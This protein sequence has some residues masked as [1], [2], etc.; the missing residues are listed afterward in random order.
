M[1]RAGAAL[2]LALSGCSGQ[3][4]IPGVGEPIVVR[5]A[6]FIS[7]PLPGTPPLDGGTPA[8]PAVTAIQSV[9]NAFVLGQAGASYSG[10]VSDDATAVAVRFP[11]FGTGY[12]VFVPGPPDA[13]D[14]GNLT[15]SM[16]FD[17]SRDVPPGLTTLR[18]AAIGPDGTSGTEVDQPVC[19]DAPIPDNYNA[20]FSSR[21]PP[22][23]VLSLSWDTPVDLDLQVVTPA[24]V[25]VS[26]KHPTTRASADAGPAPGDGAIDRD[27]DAN[28][29]T[30]G[31]NR[32]DL[33]WKDPPAPGIY[34]AYASLFSACGRPAVRFTLSLYV[35]EPVDGGQTLARKIQTSGELLATDENGG[36]GLGLYV[37]A[38]TFPS[39]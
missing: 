17:V 26:P 37:A 30:D 1:K 2:L 36:T 23:A 14:P 21:V 9:N 24:G 5:G 35:A 15:W 32:E 27:S 10:D 3:P 7:G 33:V 19:I 31:L 13:T 29:V 39:P 20:C 38:V 22:A 16:T 4:V 18:F 11:D 34:L 6:T 12:W 28:C 25:V 8:L